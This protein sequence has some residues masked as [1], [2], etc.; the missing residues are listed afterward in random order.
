MQNSV[1]RLYVGNFQKNKSPLNIRCQFECIM[2]MEGFGIGIWIG[3]SS[4]PVT[5]DLLIPKSIRSRI[6]RP[7]LLLGNINIYS[8]FL[9]QIFSRI[10]LSLRNVDFWLYALNCYKKYILPV[11]SFWIYSHGTNM[12]T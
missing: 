4:V 6:A 11:Y 5:V 2:E 9:L 12:F 1:H 7:S 10:E 3:D 8:R